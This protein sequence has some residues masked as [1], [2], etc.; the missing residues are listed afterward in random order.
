MFLDYNVSIRGLEDI[1]ILVRAKLAQVYNGCIWD[2][3]M[4]LF[5]F[6]VLLSMKVVIFFYMKIKNP[7]TNILSA[8]CV[9]LG[10]GVH[11]SQ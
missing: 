6:S 2:Y 9:V 8:Y 10:G 5:I 1:W 7:A 11:S 3:I 4:E